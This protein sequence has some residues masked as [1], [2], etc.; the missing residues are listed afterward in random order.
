MQAQYKLI[1]SSNQVYREITLAEP[2]QKLVVGTGVD[3]DIRFRKEDFFEPF[4]FSVIRN[5]AGWE[6]ECSDKIYILSSDLR[7]LV[8]QPLQLDTSFSLKYRSSETE[9][10][11]VYFRQ[12][13]DTGISA[14]DSRID[15]GKYPSVRVGN[16]KECQIQLLDQSTG[17]D[18][19]VIQRRQNNYV[20]TVEQKENQVFYN[21]TVLTGSVQL[22]QMDFLSVGHCRFCFFDG[23][24]Y[25]DQK[26]DIVWR[27][28]EG[29]VVKESLSHQEYPK[30]HRSSRIWENIPDEK[31]K[32]LD[33]PSEPVKPKSNIAAQL[34]PAVAMLVIIVLLRGV[35]N[36]SGLSFV[37]FSACS[38]FI[39]VITT[40]INIRS[41]KKKYKDSK[42]QREESYEKYIEEKRAAIIEKRK[43]EV[44]ILENRH[45][46][47]ERE[48]ENIRRFSPSLFD[49]TEEAPDF[50]EVRLGTGDRL[51]QQKIEYRPQERVETL[52]RLMKIPEA[53]AEEF[54]KVRQA[55][56][57]LQIKDVSRV[58]ITGHR[59]ALYNML[60]VVTLDLFSRQYYADVNLMY[61][62]GEEDLKAFQ[63]LRMLPHLQNEH[64]NRRNIICD[65]ESRSTFLEYL[66][67]RLLA[68]NENRE[69]PRLVVFV[70]R[71]IHI[72]THPLSAFIKDAKDK[73]ITFIFFDEFEEFI[74]AGCEYVIRME[75]VHKG[76]KVCCADGVKAESFECQVLGDA[77]IDRAVRKLAPVYCEKISLE[78][79][80]TR[81]ISFYELLHIYEPQDLDLEKCWSQSEVYKTMAA[82]IGVKSK[83]QKVYLD[84]HERAHGPHG[85][86]A[87]TTGSGKSELLQSYI[88]S[89]A[90]RYHPYDVGFVIIDFKGGGMANQFK[91]LP[92][93][94]GS[95]TNMG[96]RETQRSLLSIRAEIKKRQEIFAEY[97][98][99]HIDAYIRLFKQNIAEKP[100]PHLI[101][102]VDE[103]AELKME[104]PE[105]MKELISAARI[106]RSLGVHLILATQK[107]SG[108][109]D[110]Q[111]WS[112]SRFHLCLKVQTRED[113]NEVLKSP[114]AADIAEPGRA[115]FQVGNNEI[116]ELFQS[117]Y[118]GGPATQEGGSGKKSFTISKI[119][120]SGKRIPAYEQKAE[121]SMEKT[122]SQLDSV[123]SYVSG[124]CQVNQIAR[125]PFI[126]LPPLPENIAAPLD[127]KSVNIEKGL[128]AH[129]GIVDDPE[130]QQQ[131]VL[132]LNVTQMNTMLIGSA[133]NGKTNFL[134]TVVTSLASRYTAKQL[135]LYLMDFASMILKNYEELPQV[136]GVVCAQ[137]EEKCKN[138][139]RMLS[140]EIEERKEKFIAAGV[141]SFASYLE[142]GGLE[143]PQ[144]VVVIDNLTA[145][146]E[147]YLMENDFF[148]P[149][150][151][152]GI[153]VGITFVIA[154]AQTSG[155]GYKYLANFEQRMALTCNDT[156]EYNALF[157]YCRMHPCSTPGRCLIQQNKKI[158][159]AQI[160]LAFDGSKEKE[161]VVRILHFVEKEK[162]GWNKIA[163][164]SIPVVPEIVTNQVLSEKFGCESTA[165]YMPIG[166]DFSTVRPV[167]LDWKRQNIL[168]VSGQ[169]E[170][171]RNAFSMYLFQMFER[172][173][174]NIFVLDDYTRAFST[175]AHHT[176]IE[177]YGQE[178]ED[179][180]EIL[181][182]IQ[183]RLEERLKLVIKQGREIVHSF[184]PIVLFIQNQAAVEYISRK[185]E[186]IKLYKDI[187]GKYQNLMCAIVYSNLENTPIG[188]NS[189]EVLKMMRDNRQFIVFED[190]KDVKV[191]ET[192]G[193][194]IRKFN[195]P[196]SSQ[197]AY[198]IS[199][200]V[201]SKVKTAVTEE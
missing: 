126:C 125:L 47:P 122:I 18:C 137:E 168:A 66:Y 190:L 68:G 13:F 165:E 136:G 108:V 43:E 124:F 87:G 41:E 171:E 89:M 132:S 88:L 4:S 59:Q 129:V 60:K 189:P 130:N 17:T 73:G 134:Q 142:S 178:T 119:T 181:S 10:L 161:R 104:Q 7:K 102:V 196:R 188:F 83:N 31:I 173:G 80:L 65:E 99:N 40:I 93:L 5:G 198:F 116:F 164:R 182:E 109:V 63:W 200:T 22:R 158:Y 8:V 156:T 101:L 90:L 195:R 86:V 138:L 135:H 98:V 16:N 103:F 199:G 169:D 61:C 177:L 140:K 51:A 54:K 187:L 150:C 155:I 96:G 186:L 25:M 185:P 106:G 170:M 74:P 36:S 49:R 159:E 42:K 28:I 21:G 163:A 144:I 76:T 35:M 160:Y 105:F 64:L 123:V 172:S 192:S 75:E 166:V 183:L 48:L 29:E 85:L 71:D 19:F 193:A 2:I 153:A 34:F 24:L 141:S 50:M 79:S 44:R 154:N 179:I 72:E 12:D 118:S 191:F 131:K 113:S 114:L 117:A 1:L 30:F 115:Y 3:T 97:N 82:P 55:P 46:A 45:Y 77:D 37:L 100:L 201:L 27:G 67:K 11:T 175:C 133:Q 162:Q 152:E 121:E 167:I 157:E 9:L 6:L 176:N 110:P 69:L 32:I 194:L 92:H 143:I 53:L 20:V 111:I 23:Y 127:K 52:D 174:A 146:R 33:P 58:G 15:L 38:M 148:L 94:I 95:I 197:D 147:L 14:Y 56:V 149:V 151:R 84:L 139:F 26:A 70:Y 57:T 39:G 128:I 107:P 91:E 81:N 120:F 112:N 145:F 62:I 78:S 180:E 184:V